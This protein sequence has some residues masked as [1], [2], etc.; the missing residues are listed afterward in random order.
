M[1]Q[2]RPAGHHIVLEVPEKIKLQSYPG[3]F[4]QVI[5]N[6]INNALKHAFGEGIEG[7]TRIVA[8]QP[9]AG[10]VQIQFI[11]NGAGISEENV[12]RIFDP[13]FTTKLGQGGSGLG[14]NIGFNIITSLLK[15]QICVHST[16]GVGTTFLLDL[17][18]LVEKICCR[19]RMRVCMM[20]CKSHSPLFSTSNS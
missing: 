20:G 14:L 17:P 19:K 11:D 5:T 9:I 13:F 12:K 4:G 18:L 10:R 16:V 7:E 6:F 8:S 1:S 3:P 2:I 15:G